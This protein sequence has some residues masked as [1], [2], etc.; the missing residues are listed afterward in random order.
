MLSKNLWNFNFYVFLDLGDLYLKV[1][2]VDFDLLLL[3]IH[4]HPRFGSQFN[5]ANVPR[6]LS[7]MLLNYYEKYYFSI[8]VAGTA[9]LYSA[10][11]LCVRSLILV[12]YFLYF[13]FV[14]SRILLHLIGSLL[15]DTNHR[16]YLL[17]NSRQFIYEPVII[18]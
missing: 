10:K 14:F 12:L 6:Y 8:V 9:K 16:W 17:P 7:S 11:V 2:F 18:W 5:R 13:I 15:A 4:W 1:S 3:E